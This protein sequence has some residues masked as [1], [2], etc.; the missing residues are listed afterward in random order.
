MSRTRVTVY[1]KVDEANPF[2]WPLE[3]FLSAHHSRVVPPA[4]LLKLL[5]AG[6]VF[7]PK[8][9]DSGLANRQRSWWRSLPWVF[10]PGCRR[11]SA[12]SQRAAMAIVLVALTLVRCA[13]HIAAVW[14]SQQACLL[15]EVLLSRDHSR[16]CSGVR[17][18]VSRQA[19]DGVWPGGR[20]GS[21]GAGAL[22]AGHAS[23]GRERSDS[24]RGR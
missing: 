10:H 24:S 12:W 5:F 8:P 7:L 2:S 20:V 6:G 21:I 23:P 16:L 9:P 11:H 13:S 15:P 4:L 19:L 3:C 17:Y 22:A 14:L 1:I 18:S